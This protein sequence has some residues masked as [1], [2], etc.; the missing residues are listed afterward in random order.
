MTD[1][2]AA[3]EAARIITDAYRPA[4]ETPTAYR[5]TTPLPR[6]GATP[7]VAQP[8]IPPMS[9]TATDAG[10]LMLTAGLATV[11]PGLI[12]IGLLIA[13]QHADPTVLALLLGAPAVPILALARLVRRGKEALPDVHHHHY[14]GPVHQDRRTVHTTTR[15]V[16]AKTNNQEAS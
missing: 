4:P 3:A 10:R 11:P 2:E 13:S 15:G 9:Q 12:A 6:Y 14:K 5:D 16:W 7:P 1:A 8:G